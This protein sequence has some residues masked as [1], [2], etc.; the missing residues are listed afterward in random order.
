VKKKYFATSRDKNEWL[1][2]TKQMDNISIKETDTLKQTTD[3]KKIKKLDLHGF[4]LDDANK[5]VEKFIIESFDNDYK[6]LLIITGKGMRSK[7]YDNPY[8]SKKLS[9]L[10]HSVPEYIESN[11]NLFNK[12]SKMSKADLKDGGDGA[13]YILLK[14]NKKF[15]E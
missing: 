9:V 14:K 7:S 4:S 5:E 3:Q 13:I 12:I 10:K 1:A 11:E 6:K 8:L 15:I 2:F